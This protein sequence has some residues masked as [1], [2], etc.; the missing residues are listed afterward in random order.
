MNL[1]FNNHPHLIGKK[2]ISIIVNKQKYNFLEIWKILTIETIF[3]LVFFVF[4]AIFL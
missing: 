1:T 2:Y 4:D 3:L